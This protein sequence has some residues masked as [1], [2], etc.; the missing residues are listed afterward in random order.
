MILSHIHWSKSVYFLKEKEKYPRPN[1]VDT[2]KPFISRPKDEK[3]LQFTSNTHNTT[4]SSS[5][6]LSDTWTSHVV[7]LETS[8]APPWNFPASVAQNTHTHKLCFNIIHACP[9]RGAGYK[10]GFALFNQKL[11]MT[12]YRKL[13][14]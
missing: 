9:C 11:A 2:R 3:Q 6:S 12:R 13:L 5:S 4:T 7:P 8:S 14:C 1:K 10:I